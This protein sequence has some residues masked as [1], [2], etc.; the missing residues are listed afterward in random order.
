[1]E[2]LADRDGHA[3]QAIQITRKA[4]ILELVRRSASKNRQGW[5]PRTTASP[6]R[7]PLKDPPAGSAHRQS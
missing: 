2:L 3:K 5:P 6:T 4:E 1:M 7:D